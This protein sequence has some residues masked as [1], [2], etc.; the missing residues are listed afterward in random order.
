MAN[1]RPRFYKGRP[2]RGSFRAKSKEVEHANRRGRGET[3]TEEGQ[4]TKRFPEADPRTRHL[5]LHFIEQKRATQR[6]NS[7]N[8][9]ISE[10]WG[11][12][13]TLPSGSRWASASVL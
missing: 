12:Q 8:R 9:R 3:Q 5:R 2:Q 13:G 1:M 11:A 10:G 4:N 7:A 6:K